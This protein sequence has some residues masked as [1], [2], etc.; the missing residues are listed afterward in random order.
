MANTY[1]LISGVTVGV[2][3][4][5]NIDFTSI[6]STYT[7][8][9]LK[10]SGRTANAAYND[11]IKLTFNGSST[12]AQIK[13]LYG[14]G[15]SAASDAD[16]SGAASINFYSTTG[17]TATTSTFGNAEFY[18]PN[19]AGSNQKS[20]SGDLVTENNATSAT[21]ALGAGLWANTAAI[22]QITLTPNSGL[23]FVQYSTAYLYGVKNA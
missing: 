5:A 21:A 17:G 20:I 12:S 16:G 8:L 13:R 1:E 14:N 4:A 15:A 3:G 18:I 7:D 9:I 22:T 10:V 6:G 23:T 19:Y 11:T 2:G